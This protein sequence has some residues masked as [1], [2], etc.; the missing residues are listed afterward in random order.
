[1]YSPPDDDDD[2]AYEDSDFG[3]RVPLVDV[4]AEQLDHENPHLVEPPV[5]AAAQDKHGNRAP[6]IACPWET[7]FDRSKPTP[8]APN[9]FI[10]MP[11]KA[12]QEQKT[13]FALQRR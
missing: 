11:K 13:I 7:A 9:G 10:A 1:V 3:V 5:E 8:I 4:A 2:N 12:N 6:F